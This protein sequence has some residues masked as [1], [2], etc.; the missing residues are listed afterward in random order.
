MDSKGGAF[1]SQTRVGKDGKHFQLLKFRTMRPASE[2]K[3]QLTVGKDPRITKVG[4]TL[5]KYKLDEIPQLF[6]ILKGDMSVVGPRPEVPKYVALYNEEQKKVLA[7]RPGLTDLAS[8]EY[9]NE[10]EVLSKSTNPEET[11]IKEI[12]PHKLKLNLVYIKKQSFFFDLQLIFKT[13]QPSFAFCRD[14]YQKEKR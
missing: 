4:H 2:S 8:I 11:Y 12:M 10:N 6:N 9:I 13:H 3:G 14:Y 7:V 5:R 1:F